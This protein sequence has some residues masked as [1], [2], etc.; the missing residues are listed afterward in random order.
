MMT[1]IYSI[2]LSFYTISTVVNFLTIAFL[3]IFVYTRNKDANVN[4]IFAIYSLTA[5]QWS[6]FYF[7]WLSTKEK[8]LA[9]T[10]LRTCMIGIALMPAAFTHFI[11]YF[12]KGK[13]NPK[14]IFLNYLCSVFVVGIIYT[15]L[16]AY[17]FEPFLVFPC[18]GIAGMLFPF[19]LA[20]F[21]ANILY[22][23]YIMFRA[24]RQ[25]DSIIFK[26]Q[27]G[28]V[29]IGTTIG[30]FGGLSNYLCWYH[31]PFPPVLNI[32]VSVYV[33]VVAYAIIR[34]RLLDI[35]VVLTR[36]GIFIIVCIMVSIPLYLGALG[37]VVLTK[38]LGVNWWL[39]PAIASG[40][41]AA[42]GQF[43]Y[44]YFKR[45]ADSVLLKDQ[46]LKHA[47][48]AAEVQQMPHVRDREKL[49]DSIVGMSTEILDAAFASVY[50]LDRE[51]KSYSFC[52]TKY[53]RKRN[54]KIE[55]GNLLVKYLINTKKPVI[56]EELKREYDRK[57]DVFL[58]EVLNTMNKLNA[59]VAV[60]FLIEAELIGFLVLGFKKSGEIYSTDDLNVLTN[61]ASQA[62]LAIENAQFL[63]EREEM[64]TKLREEQTLKAIGD[65]AGIVSHEMGNILNKVSQRVQTMMRGS[66]SD[67]SEKF[68]ESLES[69]DGNIASAKS[70]W[71]SINE[72]K[73]KSLANIISIHPLTEDI[74]R[75]FNHSKKLMEAWKIKSSIS[76]INSR[77]TMIG[78]GTLPDIFKHLVINSVYGMETTGGEITYS[79]KVMQDKGVIEIVQEDTGSGLAE[80][81][82][83]HK[84]CG[85][86]F[87]AEQ[88]KQGGV[89]FYI[90][91]QIIYDHKGT[92]ELQSNNGKG[93][94]F[95]I[96]LPLDFTRV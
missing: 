91:R 54:I 82:A 67:N 13:V 31:I 14:I 56:L 92:L 88:G 43:T 87:F 3:G 64:Q 26:K 29:L 89:S 72:Y 81:I 24:I 28:Y 86:E 70:I 90:A 57:H 69:M 45:R 76:F 20:H 63:K 78:A 36:A 16:F 95:V 49:C 50:L 35:N 46:Y 48:L 42:A 59:D 8:Q 52:V 32:L 1:F 73:E 33:C 74:S 53:G 15:P 38:A 41:L 93:T 71:S 51:K 6:L 61:L 80:D 10:Y 84:T 2:P 85:G 68:K 40:I 9:E 77:I 83:N 19:H 4:K 37:R 5:A 21:F 47:R 58:K 62:A 39:L 22:S 7:L 25:S 27:V 96:R 17:N 65:L 23:D 34:Y 30:Y 18:W 79:A 12:V 66:P 94:K 75:A 55:P 60:P 11:L 44:L